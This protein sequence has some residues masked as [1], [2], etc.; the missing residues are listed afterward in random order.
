MRIQQRR[1]RLSVNSSCSEEEADAAAAAA[2]DDDADDDDVDRNLNKFVLSLKNNKTGSEQA[3]DW[4][5]ILDEKIMF[6]DV[7]LNAGDMLFICSLIMSTG[8]R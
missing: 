4:Q 2:D 6:D 5:A 1:R 3:F 7:K 8:Q